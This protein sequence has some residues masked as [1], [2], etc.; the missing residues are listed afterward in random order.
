MNVL[1]IIIP[2]LA[3]GLFVVLLASRTK[4]SRRQDGSGDGA[5]YFGEVEGSREGGGDDES[6]GDDGS[7]DGAGDSGGGDGGGNGGGGSD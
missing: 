5:L 2:V 6:G 7:G 4:P 3:A 1:V